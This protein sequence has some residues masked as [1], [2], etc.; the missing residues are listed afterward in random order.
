MWIKRLRI[1]KVRLLFSRSNSNKLTSRKDSSSSSR[2]RIVSR[3]NLTSNNS[4]IKTN[5]TRI[6]RSLIR[7]EGNKMDKNK[8]NK[9]N[10]AIIITN[11]IIINSTITTTKITNKDRSKINNQ[12]K[13]EK[14]RRFRN[15][16]YFYLK[17]KKIFYKKK[18]S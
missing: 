15:Y 1:T 10:K 5:K 9:D 8:D 6:T 11:R 2:I 17:K 16:F 12:I 4:K 13:I 14:N 3:E 7:T 18:I